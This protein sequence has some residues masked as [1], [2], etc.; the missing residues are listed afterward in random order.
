LILRIPLRL[1]SISRC[2]IYSVH[3]SIHLVKRKVTKCSMVPHR[4]SNSASRSNF[5]AKNMRLLIFDVMARLAYQR[6]Q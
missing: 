6:Y 1:I 2:H 5:L 3:D 4:Q